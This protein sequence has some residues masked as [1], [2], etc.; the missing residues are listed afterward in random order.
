MEIC[1]FSIILV[2]TLIFFFN[3]GQAESAQRN[4]FSIQDPT[5]PLEDI[6]S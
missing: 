3:L 5:I 1:M 2:G 6:L 4:G